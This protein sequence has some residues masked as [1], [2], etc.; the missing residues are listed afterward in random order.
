VVEAVGHGAL[1]SQQVC[2]EGALATGK[3]A[4]EAVIEELGRT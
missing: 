4:A 1:G 2:T 3:S